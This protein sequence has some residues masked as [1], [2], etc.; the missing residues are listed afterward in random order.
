[1]TNVF[2][3][4][5]QPALVHAVDV[6]GRWFE[7]GVGVLLLVASLARLQVVTGRERRAA[8]PVLSG[9][10]LVGAAALV[11]ALL[12]WARIERPSDSAFLGA[13]VG[14]AI[15]LTIVA[16]GPLL[17]LL[18]DEAQR[19]SLGRIAAD[20]A[21]RPQHGGLQE[22]LAVAVGDPCLTVG[23]WVPSLG[24]FV[25]ASGNR[26]DDAGRQH[27][28]TTLI[29]N[30]APLA[31]IWHEPLVADMV[32]TVGAGTQL[33]VDNER[34]RAA[35][36]VQAEE[37]TAS[38]ERILE[39][40]DAARR[41]AERDLHDGA[42]QR[43]LALSYRLR[44]ALGAAERHG[45]AGTAA[46]VRA[47]LDQT[48]ALLAA[49]RELAHGIYPVE[50]IQDGLGSALEWLADTAA[51]PVD[52]VCHVE[53][54]LHLPVAT[55]A[56]IVVKDAIADAQ[57]RFATAVDVSVEEDKDRVMVTV[58]DDGLPSAPSLTYA[59]DRAATLGGA[60]RL[61]VR[62]VEAQIPCG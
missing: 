6:A 55:T 56:Y 13:F 21:A 33:M 42:Q 32:R 53:R 16:A 38:R 8:W 43:L 26:V 49:L 44:L 54:A 23:Y 22:A 57:S 9:T 51:V 37:I 2:L 45:D 25:D 61:G 28:A 12:L 27:G 7:G 10:A 52:L 41:E 48:L 36:L 46:L 29:R 17:A 47:A 50:L 11:H 18:R 62:S 1:V 40:G 35:M 20:L 31:R 58:R 14:L 15:G 30:G 24:R 60:V 3:L 59:Q 39:S 5:S 4:R 19:R 34:L